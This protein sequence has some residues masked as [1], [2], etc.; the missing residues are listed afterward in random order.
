MSSMKS[1]GSKPKVIRVL[2]LY[3]MSPHHIRGGFADVLAYHSCGSNASGL[4]KHLGVDLHVRAWT[5]KHPKLD[6]KI[7]SHGSGEQASPDP[8]G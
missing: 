1:R 4:I 5:R 7:P 8:L 2:A 6:N 3:G